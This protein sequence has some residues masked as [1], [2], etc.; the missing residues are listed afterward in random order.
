MNQAVFNKFAKTWAQ[1]EGVRTNADDVLREC[2]DK[3]HHL[4]LEVAS[5]FGM[6]VPS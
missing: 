1:R 2:R 3:I 5:Y 4:Y 6:Q